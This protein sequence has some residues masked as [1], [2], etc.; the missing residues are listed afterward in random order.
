[1]TYYDMIRGLENPFN[2]R[3]QMVKLAR[4]EREYLLLLASIKL[5]VT[6]YESGL[7]VIVKREFSRLKI[8]VEL[9]NTFLIK[10]REK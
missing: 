4:S 5:L 9:P 3:L 7:I 6:Q 10:L 8:K 2:I 1:M